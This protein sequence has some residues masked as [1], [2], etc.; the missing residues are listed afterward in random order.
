MKEN[1]KKSTDISSDDVSSIFN[2]LKKSIYCFLVEKFKKSPFSLLHTPKHANNFSENSFSA[3]SAFRPRSRL[4]GG[5]VIDEKEMKSQKS[6]LRRRDRKLKAVFVA[7]N[8]VISKSKT[9]F[10]ITL[11]YWQLGKFSRLTFYLKS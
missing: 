10:K 5:G 6:Q 9:D 8:D 3:F 2:T 7:E 11:K 1:N 4:M